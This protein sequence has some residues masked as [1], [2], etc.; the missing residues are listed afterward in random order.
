MTAVTTTT[1]PAPPPTGWVPLIVHAVAAGF[2]ALLAVVGSFGTITGTGERIAAI[3]AG[4]VVFA[5]A[6]VSYIVAHSVAAAHVAATAR[7]WVIAHGPAFEKAVMDLQALKA[8]VPTDLQPRLASIADDASHALSLAQA[9]AQATAPDLNAVADVVFARVQA[10]L[11]APAMTVSGGPVV[12][13]AGPGPVV[14]PTQP[15]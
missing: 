11:A 4:A 1:K 5:L 15:G 14:G 10:K 12:P 8:L 6:A 2:G 7:A 13:P 9:A 3:V